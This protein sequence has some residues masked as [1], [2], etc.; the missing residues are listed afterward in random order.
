MPVLRAPA[1][2]SSSGWNVQPPVNGRPR[3]QG[4]PGAQVFGLLSGSQPATRT[5]SP[6]PL[7]SPP[8]A[9]PQEHS[10]VAAFGERSPGHKLTSVCK[11]RLGSQP[12][13]RPPL[14]VLCSGWDLQGEGPG[15]LELMLPVLGKP[16]CCLIRPS[17]YERCPDSWKS[18]PS[19]R[20]RLP[21]ERWVRSLLPALGVSPGSGTAASLQAADQDV[22]EGPAGW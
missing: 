22:Q 16:A 10:G 7:T 5:L 2:Q 20:R 9:L 14:A 4:T 13:T 11:L 19:G 18:K 15:A 8:S 1:Q 12:S 6:R 17:G 21:W 3:A